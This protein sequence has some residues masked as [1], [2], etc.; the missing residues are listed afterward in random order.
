M[1]PEAPQPNFL[2][3]WVVSLAMPHNF[4][5]EPHGACVPLRLP[6]WWSFWTRWRGL[7][8]NGHESLVRGFQNRSLLSKKVTMTK[9]LGLVGNLKTNGSAPAYAPLHVNIQYMC[10]VYYSMHYETYNVFFFIILYIYIYTVYIYMILYVNHA[11]TYHCD[12]V[13]IPKK[14]S[15]DFERP[16]ENSLSTDLGF[17]SESDSGW[18]TNT[19]WSWRTVF[20]CFPF[21][22]KN[23]DKSPDFVGN[24]VSFCSCPRSFCWA[25]RTTESPTQWQESHC[26]ECHPI[27]RWNCRRLG[28]GLHVWMQ[29]V[30]T[31]LVYGMQ[32]VLEPP[33]SSTHCMSTSIPQ[34]T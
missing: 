7:A 26:Q 23:W 6:A 1:L 22:P 33:W 12:Y 14:K 30:D 19:R 4:S 17:W 31:M 13:L 3:F 15:A 28:P 29:W 24:F 20:Q 32:T 25:P 21:F 34:F 11:A 10:T 9:L 5:S 16:A 2:L 27:L 8:G 18:T